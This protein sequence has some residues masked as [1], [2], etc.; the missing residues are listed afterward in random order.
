MSVVPSLLH[1]WWSPMQVMIRRYDWPH[2][3]WF[4]AN[5][6]ASTENGASFGQALFAVSQE[7][8]SGAPL[9]PSPSSPPSGVPPLESS[10][11]PAATTI[12]KAKR[13]A[14]LVRIGSS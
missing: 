2:I 5:L 3:G 8:P 14:I 12:V 10:E 4:N 1:T 11:Q 7:N 6:H 13:E 9:D